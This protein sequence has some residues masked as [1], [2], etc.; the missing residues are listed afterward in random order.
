MVL[1]SN[2]ATPRLY[3]IQPKKLSQKSFFIESMSMSSAMS[4][5][6]SLS[7]LWWPCIFCLSHI[8][9]CTCLQARRNI[10]QIDFSRFFKQILIYPF[11]WHGASASYSLTRVTLLS[12]SQIQSLLTF[13]TF[14]ILVIIFQGACNFWRRT[15]TLPGWT[16]SCALGVPY[17]R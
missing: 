15:L 3:W 16:A 7:K 1:T 5:A 10:L 6:Q 11:P 2:Q 8:S 13:W 14:F 9:V 4:L 17:H 12:K